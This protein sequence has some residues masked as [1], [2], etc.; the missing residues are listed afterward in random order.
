MQVVGRRKYVLE[1]FKKRNFKQMNY[2]AYIRSHAV[3]LLSNY[4]KVKREQWE[5]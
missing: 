3:V 1:S 4:G 5:I 2:N